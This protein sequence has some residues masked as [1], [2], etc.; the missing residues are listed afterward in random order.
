M[1]ALQAEV[2]HV[3]GALMTSQA[4]SEVSHFECDKRANPKR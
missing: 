3:F 2:R 4:F 1:F